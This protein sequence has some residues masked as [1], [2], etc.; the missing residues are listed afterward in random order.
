M[1]LYT[2][3]LGIAR[4]EASNIVSVLDIREKTLDE[5][6]QGGG[7]LDRLADAPSGATYKLSDLEVFSP[8]VRPSKVFCIGANYHG[9]IEEMRQV[10]ETL[11]PD[12]VEELIAGTLKTPVFFGVPSSAIIGPFADI[13]VPK[14]AAA[15]LDY[16]VELAVVIAKDGRNISKEQAWD[17]VAGLTMSNDI[18]ARD[19]QGEAMSGPQFEFAHA[20]GI[21]GFKPLGPCLVTLDEFSL[22]LDIQIEAKIN[23]EVRQAASTTEQV[24]DIPT[25]IS[26]ISGFHTLKAGD[27]ILTGSPAGVGYF[28]GNFLKDGDLMEMSAQGIGTLRNKV[29]FS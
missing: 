10:L 23:G 15:Q 13:P 28:Q 14:F 2:T 6:L 3:S 26:Y 20:K 5:V 25:C 29:K 8:V 12:R 11:Q 27:V 18:S 7:G 19:I 24:H 21:D 16:E 1:K 22:P 9:H 17:Y 4:Q